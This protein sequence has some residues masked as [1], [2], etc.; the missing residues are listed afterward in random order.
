MSVFEC[1]IEL[2]LNTLIFSLGL[3][4]GVEEQE[5]LANNQGQGRG[6]WFWRTAYKSIQLKIHPHTNSNPKELISVFNVRFERK[7]RDKMWMILKDRL[8]IST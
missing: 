6:T 3:S 8:R 5:A 2:A 1:G 4:K 7:G